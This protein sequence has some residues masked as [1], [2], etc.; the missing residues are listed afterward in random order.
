MQL[1]IDF[2][3]QQFDQLNDDPDFVFASNAGGSY[4]SNQA[5]RVLEHYNHHTR[6]Q[7][8]SHYPSSEQAGEAMDRAH[9][10]W[11]QA[12]NCLC[13]DLTSAAR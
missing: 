8:Y 3:R 2:V 9:I 11:A 6:V 12:L 10:G 1:D 7:P 13:T 5:N 4:V